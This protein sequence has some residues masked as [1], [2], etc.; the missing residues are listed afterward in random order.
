[1]KEQAPPAFRHYSQSEHLTFW[2]NDIHIAGDPAAE[3]QFYTTLHCLEQMTTEL[4]AGEVWQPVAPQTVTAELTHFNH[5]VTAVRRGASVPQPEVSVTLEH[6]YALS[7]R[8][9]L[10][11][12]DTQG[13]SAVDYERFVRLH[14]ALFLALHEE[15][16][17][18]RLRQEQATE[19][20]YSDEDVPY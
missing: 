20:G 2:A 10:A 4:T 5:S 13:A 16:E 14:A 7:Q 11:A 3:A 9:L 17:E 12:Y 6:L 19:Q 1:M 18:E 8:R 15:R